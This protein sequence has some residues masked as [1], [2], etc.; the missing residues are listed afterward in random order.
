[1][2]TY[3]W[4]LEYQNIKISRHQNEQY[5]DIDNS[6]KLIPVYHKV[7]IESLQKHCLMIPFETKSQFWM[8]VIDQELWANAFSDV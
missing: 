5:Q 3:R 2:L 1:V 4:Q 8:E 7:S 6:L